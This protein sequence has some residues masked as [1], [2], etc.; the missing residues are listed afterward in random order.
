MILTCGCDVSEVKEQ[1][2]RAC[3][4]HG[5][6]SLRDHFAG[7]ALVGLYANRLV[8]PQPKLDAEFAYLI[9]DEMLKAREAA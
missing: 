3:Q 6:I 5:G 1:I 4:V 8:A 7:Q 2:R 9:A